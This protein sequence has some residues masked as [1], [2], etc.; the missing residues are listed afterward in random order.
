M[1]STGFLATIRI[2]ISRYGNK[3]YNHPGFWVV[4]S[5]RIRRQRKL[6]SPII[7]LLLIPLD[8]GIG[9]ARRW[10]ANMRLPSSVYFGP[11]LYLPHPDGIFINDKAKFGENVSIF[12][13]VT[14]GEWHEKA[15]NVG[16]GVSFFAG[17][18]VFG[19]IRIGDNSKIG[20][21]AVVNFDIPSNSVVSCTKA[22]V[23]EKS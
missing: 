5:Y 1:N 4:F 2:D 23:I 13:Q 19:G 3:W 6:A 9:I 14:I 18:K 12:Q 10:F 8:I 17:A 20:A 15:P 11:G 21:N 16:N 22:V 7:H